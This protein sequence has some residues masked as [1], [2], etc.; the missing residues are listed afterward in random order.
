MWLTFV[1]AH[2][3]WHNQSLIS[4]IGL[5]WCVVWMHFQYLWFVCSVLWLL[6]L[7]FPI[8][9]VFSSDLMQYNNFMFIEVNLQLRC[10][11]SHSTFS[12]GCHC[13]CI[14]LFLSIYFTQIL[15]L[16]HAPFYSH[17]LFT[18]HIESLRLEN[19]QCSIFALTTYQCRLHWSIYIWFC[20]I[21]CSAWEKNFST[22]IWIID[23][24]LG[25]RSS[26]AF[27]LRCLTP[28]SDAIAFKNLI[29]K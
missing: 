4:L 13:C 17:F 26:A 1:L 23:H 15:F 7:Q 19:L 14:N 2:F 22:T 5:V 20:S 27:S 25:I 11:S 28:T 10:F 29:C 6:V 12:C 8:H 24:R 21:S 16:S 3:C 9:S 18:T